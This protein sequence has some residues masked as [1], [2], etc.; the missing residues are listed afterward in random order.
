[1]N[2]FD[3][4]AI[5]NDSFSCPGGMKGFYRLTLEI[6]FTMTFCITF[7]FCWTILLSDNLIVIRLMLDTNILLNY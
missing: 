1:M 3:V 2:N 4:A 6:P 5:K 7:L